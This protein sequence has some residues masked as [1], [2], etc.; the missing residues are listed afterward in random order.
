MVAEDIVSD[1][2]IKLWERMKK[3]IVDPIAPFLFSILKNSTLDYLKHQAVKRDVHGEMQKVLN[4]DLEIRTTSIESTD[5]DDIFSKE[6]RKIVEDTLKSFPER[7]RKIFILS[8]FDGK[9]YKEIAAL[10]S[11]SSKGVE[12]HM[13]NVM[14]VL[15]IAL[16][17]YLPLTGFLI[18][19]NI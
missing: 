12:Y 6:I 4:R 14:K 8:K 13:S 16:K 18:F 9:S 5:P 15:R 2:L 7:T 10:F 3:E 19:L 1:S 11:I 17:D